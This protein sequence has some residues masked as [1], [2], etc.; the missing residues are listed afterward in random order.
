[1]DIAGRDN[2]G[3]ILGQS[4]AHLRIILGPSWS[5]LIIL[6]ASWTILEHP[7]AVL[8]TLELP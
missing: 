1:M 5:I 7:A 2:L 3:R 8:G 6:E 4:W